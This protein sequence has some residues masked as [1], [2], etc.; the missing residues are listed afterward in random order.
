MKKEYFPSTRNVFFFAKVVI[1]MEFAFSIIGIWHAINEHLILGKPIDY[2]QDS[3][4]YIFYALPF[5][6]FVTISSFLFFKKSPGKI[7]T[8]DET[9]SLFVLS[10]WKK[11]LFEITP[12]EITKIKFKK[13]KLIAWL[14]TLDKGYYYP[15]DLWIYISNGK[16][17]KVPWQME[18]YTNFVKYIEVLSGFKLPEEDVQWLE[19]NRGNTDYNT[20][21]PDFR[22]KKNP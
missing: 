17:L 3:K 13:T 6:I 16:I 9:S 8:D 18:N 7:V 14:E 11:T 20:R 21:D 4:I 19:K 10:F 12:N 15:M 1:L 2:S 5:W 22:N